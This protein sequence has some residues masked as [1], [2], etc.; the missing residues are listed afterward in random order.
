MVIRRVKM[1]IRRVKMVI[2]RVKMVIRWVKMVIRR[3][4]MVIGP[5]F[6]EERVPFLIPLSYKVSFI[7]Y[8]YW[9][10]WIHFSPSCIIVYIW[11][12]F[13]KHVFTHCVSM[14]SSIEVACLQTQKK[15]KSSILLTCILAKCEH[16]S[17]HC[18]TICRER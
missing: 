14:S 10:F 5:R 3:V 16:C 18:V 12:M 15:K 1:V 7:C 6:C 9:P 11:P 8:C 4:K 13:N 17:K 2:R